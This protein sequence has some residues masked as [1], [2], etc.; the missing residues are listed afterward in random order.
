[1]RLQPHECSRRDEAAA[2]SEIAGSVGRP[3]VVVGVTPASAKRAHVIEVRGLSSG[4]L[5][6]QVADSAISFINVVVRDGV[7][8]RCKPAPCLLTP[9]LLPSL[10][11][12]VG[13]PLAPRL[14]G[15]VSNDSVETKTLGILLSPT[16]VPRAFAF[17][18][19]AVVRFT[20]CSDCVRV[21]RVVAAALILFGITVLLVVPRAIRS[22]AVTAPRLQSVRL[23][24]AAIEGFAGFLGATP[25]T[26]LHTVRQSYFGH[27]P[28]EVH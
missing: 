20:S 10:L 9:A 18:M 26:V 5:Q 7:G 27:M 11:G 21:L 6:A 13:A 14:D 15:S 16:F 8:L 3:H 23:G 4:R 17:W 12:V 22:L 2:L 25:A 24:G 28:A 19:R 1:M